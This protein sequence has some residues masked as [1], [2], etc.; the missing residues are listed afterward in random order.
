MDSEEVSLIAGPSGNSTVMSQFIC[1]LVPLLSLSL[2]LIIGGYDNHVRD[3]KERLD[4]N[5]PTSTSS[6]PFLFLYYILDYSTNTL[7]VC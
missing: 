2:S 3:V 1:P 7:S 5:L 4:F 6:S